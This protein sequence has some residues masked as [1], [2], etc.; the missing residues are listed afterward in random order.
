MLNEN[1]KTGKKIKHMYNETIQPPD[2][3]AQYLGWGLSLS[4][5]ETEFSETPNQ[6]YFYA[7]FWI[8]S[9]TFSC[10]GF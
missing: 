8:C 4:W 3:N 10:W 2:T 1:E 5:T 6:A 7:N 9:R